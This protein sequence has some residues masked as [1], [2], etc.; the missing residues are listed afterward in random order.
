MK[1]CTFYN[2]FRFYV[3]VKRCRILSGGSV[4]FFND[5]WLDVVGVT[6]FDLIEAFMFCNVRLIAKTFNLY[7][8]K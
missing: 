5:V 7:I 1:D 3:V 4:C 8:V 6:K 2:V